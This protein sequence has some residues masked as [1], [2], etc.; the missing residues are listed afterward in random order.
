MHEYGKTSPE[1]EIEPKN[2][3]KGSPIKAIAIGLVIDIGGSFLSASILAIAYGA[4]LAYRGFSAEEMEHHLLNLDPYS[5]F[6]MITM[7]A[8]GLMT[9]LGGYVCA[10]IVNRS[11]YKFTFI[12]GFIS[13]AIGNL[14]S[15]HYSTLEGITLGILTLGCA[16]F[17]AWLR[18]VQ[19]ANTPA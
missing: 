2:L 16:L 1:S 18:V 6:Y 13:A 15:E 5:T 12:L 4:L 7:A 11:E 8:G 10:R 3:K 14:F 19:K 17:G 9:A